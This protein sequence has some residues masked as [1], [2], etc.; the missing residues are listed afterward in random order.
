LGAAD[1]FQSKD[2]KN[3][4]MLDNYILG[5]TLGQGS[6]GK[7]KTAENILTGE[8]VAI[9]IL[10]NKTGKEEITKNFMEEVRSMVT[11][12]NHANIVNI[13]DF[14]P[15]GGIYY[16]KGKET[17]VHYIPM[18]LATGGELFFYLTDSGEF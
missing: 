4:K 11:I 3:Q 16:N 9:K 17:H 8:K 5:K 14:D 12:G 1:S 10:T 6:F 2:Y 18:E 15:K 13:K 7:V